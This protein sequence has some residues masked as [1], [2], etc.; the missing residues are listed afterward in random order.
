VP[1][2]KSLAVLASDACVSVIAALTT[3]EPEAKHR[4]MHAFPNV[5][6]VPSNAICRKLGFEL[7]E[8]CE[9]QFPK[10]PLHDLQRLAPG[11]ARL[12]RATTVALPQTHGSIERGGR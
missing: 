12:V 2:P 7:L 11:P 6:N 5:E 1:G 8:T 10:G 9:F 3:A 4:S